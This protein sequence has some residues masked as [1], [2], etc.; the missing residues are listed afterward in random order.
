M[1]AGNAPQ[2]FF[3]REYETDVADIRTYDDDAGVFGTRFLRTYAHTYEENVLCALA[4]TL[5]SKPW[6]QC[7]ISITDKRTRTRSAVN[8]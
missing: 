6:P 1:A 4:G 8:Y 7:I 3:P 5:S 2:V